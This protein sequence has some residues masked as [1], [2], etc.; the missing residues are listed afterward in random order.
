M[1]A[2]GNVNCGWV[3]EV[4]DAGAARFFE[5]SCPGGPIPH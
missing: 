5:A 1:V 3:G 4:G 2:P